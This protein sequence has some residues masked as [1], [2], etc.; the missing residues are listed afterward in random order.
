MSTVELM[1]NDIEGIRSELDRMSELRESGMSNAEIAEEMGTTRY[2]VWSILG[3][4][5]E[6]KGGS[7]MSELNRMAMLRA[8]GKTNV[9]I[10]KI[11]GVSRHRVGSVLGPSGLRGRPDRSSEKPRRTVVRLTDSDYESLVQVADSVGIKK[12]RARNR[13]SQLTTLLEGIASGDL[14]IRRK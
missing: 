4:S 5:G 11:M 13:P 14:E 2:R 8:D 1:D 7:A 10:A 6:N 9:E 12:S 3:S